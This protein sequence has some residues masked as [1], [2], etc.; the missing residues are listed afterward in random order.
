M[1]VGRIMRPVNAVTINLTRAGVGQIDVPH[2]IGLLDQF[3]PL[4]L[5][6]V[7]SGIEQ[8]EFH[9]RGVLTVEREV[10]AAPI[11]SGTE[12]IRTSWPKTHQRPPNSVRRVRLR[13]ERR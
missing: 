2:H 6:I 9:F 10:Y 5:L 8:A 11:P 12:G 13:D 3:D 1:T 4:C 7:G